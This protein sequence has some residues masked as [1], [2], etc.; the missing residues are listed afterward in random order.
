[1]LQE[2]ISQR[3]KSP[4]IWESLL[5]QSGIVAYIPIVVV[6][7]LMF[8]GASWQMLWLSTD[9]ARYQCYAITFWLGS[10]GT[11]LLPASQCQFLGITSAQP[12]FHMLPTEYPPFTLLPFSLALLAPIQYYQLVFAI[13]MA[14]VA[15]LI[16]WLL[17][18]YGPRGGALAFA[19]YVLL[20]AWA[21][22]EGRY[23]LLPAACTLI[24]VMAAERK[25]WTLAYIALAF[26]VLLK[27]YPLL[28]LPALFLAEQYDART[29]AAPPRSLPVRA[30]PGVLWQ[31]LRGLRRWKWKNT[32]IFSA[33]TLG[34]TGFF[35]LLNF[36]GAVL[37]QLSYFLHRPVQVEA[38]SSTF[39][40][41]T[42][43]FG[44]PIKIVSS[45]GSL[46]IDSVL[47]GFVSAV[48]DVALVLGY[49]FILF[50]QW[51]K[52]FDLTQASIA[53]LLVFIATGKVF[54]PQY[55]IWVMPLLAYNGALDGFWLLCWGTLSF[56]TT[57]IYAYLYT[58]APS[59]LLIPYV[60]G[61]VQ[62][63]ALRDACFVLATLAFLF[64]WFHVRKRKPLPAE[65]RELQLFSLH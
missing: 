48:G 4:S 20:G 7:I 35:A 62:T 21:T 1:L 59:V 56:L 14:L 37:S 49:A 12:P 51:R 22:A 17:L 47:D 53:I 45:Y 64:N 65:Q 30:V 41:L 23:D 36:Q 25:R 40:W 28:L 50:L 38:T 60:P 55:L 15:V 61:F 44:F 10:W 42:T 27:L 58:R 9:A 11:H 16:Y 43:A 3:Y 2:Q 54:S 24:C 31:T 19:I 63:V 8:S 39:L 5:A 52:K 32:L 34:I 26:G 57:Y 18:R 46:N 13:W 29:L 6:T 33:I